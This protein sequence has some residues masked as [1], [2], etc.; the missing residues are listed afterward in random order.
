MSARYLL[1]PH[2]GM[3]HEPGPPLRTHLADL[4]RGPITTLPGASAVILHVAL[5]VEV[6]TITAEVARLTEADV[7]AIRESVREHL[8]QLVESAFIELVSTDR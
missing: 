8:E 1:R 3:V 5:Q 4:R 2:I 6:D 7:D